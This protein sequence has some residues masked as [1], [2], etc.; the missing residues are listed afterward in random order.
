MWSMAS[1]YQEGGTNI[2]SKFLNLKQE[3]KDRIINAGM[4]EFAQKG[5]ENASTN[6]IVKE[7]NISK[8]LLFHYF[9]NKKDLF[10]FL[11]DH[12]SDILFNEIY[13]EINMDEKDI[14]KRL[15]QVILIKIAIMN[16]F[17]EIIDFIA[18]AY[19]EDSPEIKLELDRRNKEKLSF[20]FNKIMED[21]DLSKFRKDQDIKS[22]INIILWT[23]EGF[24][25]KEQEKMKKSSIKELDIDLLQAEID[26]YFNLLKQ[27]FYT[28]MD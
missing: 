4:K 12:A 1:V 9:N 19:F 22:I 26:I 7:A 20:G 21:L 8:G 11:Y 10:L 6:E 27:S 5:Y 25:K 3:K 17:P 15:Q 24:S 16:K 28:S 13:E 14:F 23:V 2:F 18:V